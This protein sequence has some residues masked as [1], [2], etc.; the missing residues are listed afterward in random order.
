VA[1]QYV[2]RAFTGRA[3]IE[4]EEL[5]LELDRVV[6]DAL[7]PIVPVQLDITGERNVLAQRMPLETVVG[8]DAAQVRMPGE[9]DTVEVVGLAL[10]PVGAREYAGDRRNR[11]ILVGCHPDADALVLAR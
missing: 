6:D 3:E 10:E 9:E 4:I 5:L 8:E 11:G 2:V 7:H 1:V